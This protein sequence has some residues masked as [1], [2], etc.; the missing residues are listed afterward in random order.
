MSAHQ[1]KDKPSVAHNEDSEP[2]QIGSDFTEEEIKRI[3]RRIDLRLLPALGLMYGISL[4]DRTNVS[5]AAIA[6]M[7]DDLDLNTG[8]GYSTITLIFFVSYIV[9]Q[10]TITILCRKIGPKIFLSAACLTWGVVLIGFGFV[11]GWKAM[12]GLRVIVGVFEAG[13]FPGAVYLL[14]TWYTRYEIGKRDSVIWF[15]ATGGAWWAA[16]LALNFYPRRNHNFPGQ[17]AE[18]PSPLF[19]QVDEAKVVL[20]RLDA[21]RGSTKLEPFSLAAFLKPANEIEIWAFAFLF[22][23][24]TTVTYSFGFFGTVRLEAKSRF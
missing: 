20:Q 9:F 19:L 14:S 3:R 6:G 7:F 5:H 15:D 13:F 16:W 21:D 17:E 12:V 24:C 11:H 22:F 1:D 18:K 4:M 10:P 8:Y 23:L 2:G